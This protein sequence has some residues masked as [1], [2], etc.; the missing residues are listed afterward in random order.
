MA[1]RSN[2]AR[3]PKLIL[4]TI[5][6]F[7]LVVSAFFAG[8]H[9]A[10]DSSIALNEGPTEVTFTVH[11]DT[12]GRSISLITIAKQPVSVVATNQLSGTVTAVRRKAVYSVGDVLFEVDSRPVVLIQGDQ[13]QYRTLELGTEGEDVSD[14]QNALKE[15]GFF[16]STP[17]GRYGP[18]TR[19]A[20]RKWQGEL[21]TE[22]TGV[23]DFGSIVSVTRLPSPISIK[24]EVIAPGLHL[25]GGEPAILAPTGDRIFEM[26]INEQQQKM[27]PRESVIT[28]K[29]G[30]MTWPAI[31]SDQ[32]TTDSGV[33]YLLSAPT[34][35]AVCGDACGDLPAGEA[36]VSLISEV[37][38]TPQVTGP[39]VP[40]AALQVESNGRAYVTTLDNN[41]DVSRQRSAVTVKGIQDGI[42]VVSGIKTGEVV[43]LPNE[44]SE[45]APTVGDNAT[46][47]SD[48]RTAEDEPDSASDSGAR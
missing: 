8:R 30:E 9:F 7:M 24:S 19:E 23:V 14:L 31:I 37:S 12:V 15:M 25:T 28:V 35:G 38:I 18:S 17:D 39:A 21:G 44:G 46:R 1:K 3:T 4:A 34:G 36:E 42:A 22:I 33:V 11:E 20:V 16:D 2:V 10:G 13:P 40:V 6:L 45:N 5:V 26:P 32:K 27:I 29:N 41:R 48:S 43:V 47:Q